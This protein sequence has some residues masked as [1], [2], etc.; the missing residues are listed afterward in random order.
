MPVFHFILLLIAM[1]IM[2]GNMGAQNNC[3]APIPLLN[4]GITT[5]GAIIS[6]LQQGQADSFEVSYRAVPESFPDSAQFRGVPQSPFTLTGLNSGTLYEYRIR[7]ICQGVYSEWSSARRFITHLSNPSS[8]Q[9]NLE[10]GDNNCHTTGNTFR[11]NIDDFPGKVVGQDIFIK[12]VR[13]IVAHPWPADLTITLKNAHNSSITLS[14]DNGI[15]QNNYGDPN[16]ENCTEVTIFSD[17]ACFSIEE[18]SPPFIGTYRPEE[19]LSHLYDGSPANGTWELY[20]CDKA[21]GD[22]GELKYFEIVFEELSCQIPIVEGITEI[23]DQSFN[24]QLQSAPNCDSITI[25]IGVEGFIPSLISGQ[26]NSSSSFHVLN[27]DSLKQIITGLSAGTNYEMYMATYCDGSLSAVSCPIAVTTLCGEANITS[28]FSADSL[29]TQNCTATCELTGFWKNQPQSS[30][31]WLVIEGSTPTL[32]TGPS[33][34]PSGD[35]K[36]LYFETSGLQCE[37]GKAVLESGCLEIKSTG[38]ECDMSFQ[39]HMWGVHINKLEL[40]ISIDGGFSW[41]TLWVQNGELANGW[42]IANID[43]TEFDGSIGHFRFVAHSGDGPL[44]NIGLSDIILYHSE[45]VEPSEWIYFVDQDGDG[46]GVSGTGQ[47]FCTNSPPDGF[48]DQGGDCN[49]ND[50]NIN[51]AVTEIPCNL[52]DENCNGLE[53]DQPMDN[54]MRDS[55][56]QK[57]NESCNGLR[58]GSLEISISGG[59]PPYSVLWNSGDT[60]LHIT[61]LSPG[62]YFATITDS[63]GCKFRTSFYE[64]ISENSM[65]FVFTEVIRPTCSSTSDGAIN[66]T[67][68][69]GNPPFSYQWNNGDTTKD[70][71]GL[72][73]GHYRVTV[74]DANGCEFESPSFHLRALNPFNIQLLEKIEPQCTGGNNGKISIQPQGGTAPFEYFWSNSESADSINDQIGSGWYSVTV[75]DSAGCSVVRDSIF[76]GEPAELAVDFTSVVPPLCPGRATAEILTEISGGTFPYSVFWQNGNSTYTTKDLLRVPAGDYQLEVTDFNGCILNRTIE[77]AEPPLFNTTIDSLKNV[78]CGF[79]EDGHLEITLSGGWPSYQIFWNSGEVNT[80][81]LSGLQAGNYQFTATDQAGCKYSSDQIEIIN[82][83]NPIEVEIE[84]VQEIECHGDNNAVLRASTSS[85]RAPYLFQWSNRPPKLNSDPNDTIR[86]LSPNNYSVSVRDNTSCIGVATPVL[87]KDPPTLIIAGIDRITPSCHDSKDGVLIPEIFGGNPPLNYQ[88]SHGDSVAV[89]M[90]LSAGNYNLTVV[91][92]NGCQNSRNNINLDAPPPL[93][94]VFTLEMETDEDEDGSAAVGISGGIPPYTV[95]WDDEVSLDNDTMA[96]NL[97]AGK[98]DF[99]VIDSNNCRVDTFFIIERINPVREFNQGHLSIYPNPAK[100]QVLVTFIHSGRIE[101]QSLSLIDNLGR[102]HRPSFTYNTQN[103][104]WIDL[105]KISNGH[106]QLLVQT[107]VNIFSSAL[108]VVK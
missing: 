80:S 78:S 10:L 6:W 39:Y 84:V 16:S 86:N 5:E 48:A 65:D 108:Q 55:L 98:Y 104:L 43:L 41:D 18:G 11:I 52:I 56:I 31:N 9:L 42:K 94:L 62:V 79:R 23:T 1:I 46:F 89:A 19:P 37:G 76:L 20:I 34:A 30:L 106:Y 92:E 90:D 105:N 28:D 38:G 85:D 44:G 27:C 21:P 74:H 58:D 77:L 102:F 7:A 70:I 47:F 29:C 83:E 4:Y 96:V 107:R 3:N 40:L 33:S 57:N 81:Q 72:P 103:Q 99:T 22:I 25:E 95:I 14:S 88:W 2:P 17:A 8:C 97:S 75:T 15:G 82:E 36:Y 24:I 32:N 51:P 26:P 59:V 91:D 66:L 49:D 67:T 93:N 60:S 35:G 53:D 13:A 69:G 71:A 12:E 45:M 68:G 73:T 50:P 101:I 61:A 63:T 54:P 100:N 87:I 64:I